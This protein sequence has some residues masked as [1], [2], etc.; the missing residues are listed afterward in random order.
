MAYAFRRIGLACG[1]LTSG[2][3]IG[4]LLGSLVATGFRLAGLV[5]HWRLPTGPRGLITPES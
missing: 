4:I 2:L 3:T 1:T 5:F